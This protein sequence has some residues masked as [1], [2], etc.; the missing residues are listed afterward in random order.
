MIKIKNF[1]LP[2]SV[3]VFYSVRS[4][5]LVIL[6]VIIAHRKVS[7]SSQHGLA[8]SWILLTNSALRSYKRLLLFWSYRIIN[9]HFA[10]IFPIHSFERAEMG[11]LYLGG[12]FFMSDLHDESTDHYQSSLHC[13]CHRRSGFFDIFLLAHMQLFKGN[14]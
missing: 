1:R 11:R 9:D 5:F 14:R 8:Q 6:H 13:R 2:L 3:F 12:N 7:L 10:W 4:V